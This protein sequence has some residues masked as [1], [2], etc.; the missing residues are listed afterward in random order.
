MHL[1]KSPTTVVEHGS[2]YKI[3]VFNHL[4]KEWTTFDDQLN[5]M[6]HTLSDGDPPHSGLTLL[7]SFIQV[8]GGITCSQRLER[9]RPGEHSLPALL[10]RSQVAELDL[11]IHP[12]AFMSWR[13]IYLTGLLPIS[14]ILLPTEM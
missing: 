11:K 3:N 2:D 8:Q 9:N 4:W 13:F 6:A 12:A 1:P 14:G 5:I 10:A 7:E